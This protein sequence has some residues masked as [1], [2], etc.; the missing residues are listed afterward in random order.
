M[1]RLLNRTVC[2]CTLLLLSSQ[3]NAFSLLGPNPAWQTTLLAY[4]VNAPRGGY[5]PM[6]LGEEYRNN[7]PVLYYSF[8]SEFMNYFGPHGVDE[9]NKA[10]ALLNALPQA[11]QVDLDDYPLTSMRMNHRASALNLVDLK[12]TALTHLLAQMGICDS[13]RFVFTLRNRWTLGGPPPST[14]YFVI[15]RNYDPD[16]WLPSSYI[17]GQLWTYTTIIDPVLGV[18]AGL[19]LSEPVDPLALFG[20]VNAPVSSDQGGLTVALPFGGFWTSLTK[21]DMGAYVYLY[22]NNNYN[23]ENVPTNALPVSAGGGAWGVPGGT[24]NAATNTLVNLSVRGGREQIRFQQV[25]YNSTLGFWQTFTNQYLDTYVTNGWLYTQNLERS[26]AAPDIL[27]DAKDLQG[28]D[29]G[30]VYISFGETTL[31]WIN[32]DASN[33]EAGDSGPG[34]I[35]P[36]AGVPS[37]IF[38]FNTVGPTYFNTLINGIPFLSELSGQQLWLWGSFDGSTNAPVVYPIGTEIKSVEQLVLGSDQGSPWDAPN[39]VVGL[40]NAPGAGLGGGAV[41]P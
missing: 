14:N 39:Y 7:V 5:G 34:T 33:G 36:G 27:F 6:A 31:A 15:K 24:N 40:T 2:G 29:G 35:P 12:S 9:I 11:S 38:T 10:F 28:A 19:V 22:R 23:V 25:N 13:T 32:N 30:N 18:T 20:A 26:V 37:F 8:T 16:T 41:G 21:D 3:L 17:N 4:D 1:S